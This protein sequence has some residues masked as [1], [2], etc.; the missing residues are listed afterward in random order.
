MA[1]Q[2]PISL[3]ARLLTTGLA[4]VSTAEVPAPPMKTIPNGRAAAVR[5]AS[6][7]SIATPSTVRIPLTSALTKKTPR[8]TPEQLYFLKSNFQTDNP[9]ATPLNQLT[10]SSPKSPVTRQI[11]NTT[12]NKT[13]LN[14]AMLFCIS[15]I[16][17]LNCFN[18]PQAG[19]GGYLP[20]SQETLQ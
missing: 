12:R 8:R 18:R 20:A 17:V 9:L 2:V 19:G 11:T 4:A 10:Q 14:L 6:A 5:L 3:S 7:L 15:L 1:A 16:S 13:L